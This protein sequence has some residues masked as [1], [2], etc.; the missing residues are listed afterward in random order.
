METIF[1]DGGISKHMARTNSGVLATIN[2]IKENINSDFSK[3]ST[4]IDA[5]CGYNVYKS[6]F[7]NL[8]GFDLHY[9]TA[10]DMQCDFLTAP[11]EESSADLVLVLGSN[12]FISLGAIEENYKKAWSWVRPG[13]YLLTRFSNRNEAFENLE[14][15]I[16]ALGPESPDKLIGMDPNW[17]DNLFADLNAI[18]IDRFSHSWGDRAQRYR[19]RVNQENPALIKYIAKLQ[20]EYRLWK[21]NV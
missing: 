3:I 2:T 18:E 1:G 16:K 8:T 15:I 19:T 12:Q 4:V 13:G 7:P 9:Y 21:K 10:A 11:F 14:P 20:K 5:G 17:V 6:L